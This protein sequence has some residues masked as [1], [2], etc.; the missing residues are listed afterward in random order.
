MILNIAIVIFMV[1]ELANVLVMYCKPD[2]KYGNSMTVFNEWHKSKADSNSSLFARYMVNWVAN[3]KLIF[4]AILAV[5]LFVGDE[6]IKL[7][8][9]GATVLSI[10]LYFITLHPII[11]KLDAAGEITP[12]GYS[13]TLGFMIAGFMV[14]FAVAF[15]LHLA[16]GL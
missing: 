12:K 6:R 7:Y 10:G 15:V 13:R 8:S 3:C 16:L 1:M 2:F 5:V 11:R 9:V 4:I 14:M